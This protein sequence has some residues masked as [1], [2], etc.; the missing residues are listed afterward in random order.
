[1]KHCGD[2]GEREREEKRMQALSQLK[3][4]QGACAYKLQARDKRELCLSHC[5]LSHLP[6]PFSPLLSSLFLS[7]LLHHTNINQT[8]NGKVARSG[9][10]QMPFPASVDKDG[11]VYCAVSLI[12]PTDHSGSLAWSRLIPHFLSLSFSQQQG[13]NNRCSYT[14]H[15][16]I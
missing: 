15:G 5:F 1:M 7:F 10:C 8:G 2:A 16:Y 9:T 3:S 13:L 14:T 4:C 11:P 12:L 6:C